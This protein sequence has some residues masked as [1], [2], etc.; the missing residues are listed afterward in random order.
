MR[1]TIFIVGALL[2]AF[3]GVGRAW[4]NVEQSSQVKSATAVDQISSSTS[5]TENV[6]SNTLTS[7]NSTTSATTSPTTEIIGI[8]T[9]APDFVPA[10]TTYPVTFTIEI[11]DPRVIPAS[12][13][14][15]QT[16]AN[17]QITNIVG[18]MVQNSSSPTFYSI[19]VNVN[20][21]PGTLYYQ[22]SAAYSGLLQRVY[23]RPLAVTLTALLDS[24]WLSY[25]TKRG[26]TFL[27]PSSWLVN[28]GSDGTVT[29]SPPDVASDAGDGAASL[30][31]EYL[32]NTSGLSLSQ[33]FSGQPGPDLY[34]GTYSITTTTV[35]SIMA[36]MFEGLAVLPYDDAIVVPV[37]NGFVV[38]FSSAPGPI[39]N[40]FLR[41]L[42]LP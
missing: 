38:V 8:L 29:V 7:A 14:L 26:Y 35:S 3:L 16:N 19:S 1:K 11:T 25:T 4:L 17:G 32:S 5:A 20:Q 22:A 27:Y 6:T 41:S 31:I 40:Q 13:N 2:I 28:E 36:T 42:K 15:Q 12:V 34:T 18:S 33:F 10:N 24:A 9:S 37:G 39:L 21:P 23:S 30:I